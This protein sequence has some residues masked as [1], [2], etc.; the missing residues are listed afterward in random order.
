MDISPSTLRGYVHESS[1]NRPANY[2]YEKYTPKLFNGV[3]YFK[4]PTV[5]ETRAWNKFRY[6][7]KLDPKDAENVKILHKEFGEEI[8]DTKKLPKLWR[9]Q[10]VL[11]N[12]SPYAGATAMGNLA[13]AYRGEEFRT[14]EGIPKDMVLGRKIQESLATKEYRK[15]FIALALRNIDRHY[16]GHVGSLS[17]F[18]RTMR[19]ELNTLLGEGHGFDINEITS[20]STSELRGTHPW[21]AFVDITEAKINRG[22]LGGYQGHVSRTIAQVE[23]LLA[24]GKDAEAVKKAALLKTRTLESIKKTLT[25]PKHNLSPLQ[26]E[27]L[28]FADIIVSDKIDP[29]IYSP[30]QLERWKKKGLDIPGFA[31][32]RGWYFDVKKG[33][34]MNWN[35]LGK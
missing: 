34:P 22:V 10:N 4:D 9:V 33:T 24:Q 13:R 26:I 6:L 1:V 8:K 3:Y 14:L 11:K 25:G 12:K 2:I 7:P 16:K 31:K 23:N 28:N 18:Y 20:K 17:N 32:E 35:L 29:K 27:Q 30:K 21:A 5:Y 15:A 19:A